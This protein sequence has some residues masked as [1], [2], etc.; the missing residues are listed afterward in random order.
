[1]S[2]K[3]IIDGFLGRKKPNN[4]TPSDFDYAASVIVTPGP[5]GIK[6]RYDKST[7]D[8]PPK[9]QPGY[10]SH[11]GDFLSKFFGSLVKQQPD[12]QFRGIASSEMEKGPNGLWRRKSDTRPDRRGIET[13][14]GDLGREE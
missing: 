13:T 9:Q 3:D 2:L 8:Q 14:D 4:F 6:R 11:R 1:V 12:G 5:D 7:F 10:D